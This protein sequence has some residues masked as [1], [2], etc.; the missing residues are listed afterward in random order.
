[1]TLMI[2]L[3]L[4][5]WLAPGLLGGPA[6]LQLVQLDEKMPAYYRG[7]FREADLSSGEFLLK[8]PLTRVR[9]RPLYPR[10]RDLGPH[11][12]L[13]FRNSGVPVVA[14][15]VT[16]GDSMTYGN[17][18]TLEQNWPSYMAANLKHEH[19]NVYNMSTGGWAAVQYL[20]MFGYA[21]AFRPRVAIIAFY[22]GNDPLETFQLVYGNEHWHSL[23]PDDSLSAD[24]IPA[25][26]GAGAS[27]DQWDVVF[28]G[29]VHTVFTPRYRL[30]SND[31]DS[32][33]T[34][35]YR[36]M[37]EV[38]AR[39][40]ELAQSNGVKTIFTIIPTKELVYAA[41]VDAEG[42][43]APAD[44][45]RLVTSERQRIAGLREKLEALP[46]TR[47][48]DLLGPLQAAALGETSLYPD[49]VNGH[50]VAAGYEIIGRQL[51]QVVAELLPA[52]PSG[53]YA[54]MDD[55]SFYVLLV[56]R[57]GVWYFNSMEL[58]EANGWPPEELQTIGLRDI[59]DLPHR[60]AVDAVDPARFGPASC[61]PV[62][63][64]LSRQ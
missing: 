26:S 58:I 6:D 50:P 25:V 29:G 53:L 57:E 10:Y 24:D 49:T 36:I 51:A 27:G 1:V 9:A 5:R 32:T 62:E 42:L 28:R 64:T 19:P 13:G 41:R 45:N 30:A 60:G 17:N 12:I 31:D 2:A 18:A 11:D 55:D 35:G 16:I 38:A 22:S 52:P 23:I 8:D 4:I 20:D 56:N 14:D 59:L 37:A 15:I 40:G 34:A 7:I 63:T 54:L 21:L 33:V 43:E 61:L 46:G 39:I 48:V 3:G 44:Y 47:Y